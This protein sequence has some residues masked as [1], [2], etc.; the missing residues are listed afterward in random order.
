MSNARV[1]HNHLLTQFAELM[2]GDDVFN[3]RYE[4]G[5]SMYNCRGRCCADGVDLDIVERDRILEYAHL[6]QPH[7]D[8]IQDRNPQNWF[9]K[10]TRPDEDFP[11]G[12][13]T[14]TAL[15]ENG[16]VFLKKDGDCV[17]HIAELHVP[18]GTG[19]LKPFFCRAFPVCILDSTL[20]VDDG[21]CPDEH[22]CCGPRKNGPLAILDSLRV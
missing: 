1:L 16:C 2:V 20:C 18:K 21:Q 11:S 3:T 14:T 7:M 4:E 5:C 17:L 12:E 22:Q 15:L 13:C 9:E 19:N 10:K 8:E 6:V